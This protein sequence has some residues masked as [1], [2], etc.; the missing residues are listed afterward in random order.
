MSNLPEKIGKYEIKALA[1]E[2]NMGS[3]YVGYD[4]LHD[5]EVA[6][7]VCHLPNDTSA[8]KRRRARK[9]IHNEAHC[10]WVLRHPNIVQIYDDGEEKGEPYIVMEY[11]EGGDTLGSYTSRKDLLP[12]KSVLK[13]LYKCAKALDYAHRKGVIHRDVKP[14]NIMLT[15]SGEVKIADFG[16]AY[17][18][19]SSITQLMGVLGSPRYMSPEQVQ[20]KE[21]SG[22]TDLYSLG[23]VAYELLSGRTPFNGSSV[24]S[25]VRKIVKE[26]AT[27]IRQLRPDLPPMLE[28]VLK[29]AMQKK[30]DDRHESGQ[31]LAADLIC[32]LGE[33]DGVKSAVGDT[34]QDLNYAKRLGLARDLDFFKEFSDSELR[35]ALNICQWQ[36]FGKGEVVVRE[37]S[38]DQALFVLAEGEVDVSVMGKPVDILRQGACFGEMNYL[39]KSGRTATVTAGENIQVLK[40]DVNRIE[41]TSTACQLR[42]SKVLMETLLSRL[43]QTTDRLAQATELPAAGSQKNISY[44]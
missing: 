23:V 31:E 28:D 22:K 36:S 29:R 3:V 10:A 7:K 13:I 20:E 11:I 15:R 1:G 21:T 41:E 19:S 25:L 5:R 30:P 8:A 18:A 24:P 17:S 4:S 42:F 9:A 40:A 14:T 32:V 34:I 26:P 2:G 16:L 39:S 35:E 44:R 33:L 27:S 6:L 37:G 43:T 38:E 12:V